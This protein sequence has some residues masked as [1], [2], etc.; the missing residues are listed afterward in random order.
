MRPW[1]ESF[2]NEGAYAQVTFHVFTETN[3]GPDAAVPLLTYSQPQGIYGA[4]PILLDFYLT[5]APLRFLAQADPEDEIVDWRVRATINGEQFLIDRWEPIYLTGFREGQNWIKLE[6]L[7]DNGEPLANR[8]N[9]TAQLLEYYPGG[10]DSLSRLVRGELSPDEQ[11]ALLVPRLAI[12][13]DESPESD[14]T[15]GDR[16]EG[17]E[18]PAVTGDMSN[19]SLA[20]EEPAMEPDSPGDMSDEASGEPLETIAPQDTSETTRSDAED[21]QPQSLEPNQPA[22]ETPGEQAP[23]PSDTTPEPVDSERLDLS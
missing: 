20:I 8:F 15:L 11:Q 6:F 16:S 4:E 14:E 21:P 17:R 9:T 10:T 23:Q 19:Q 18:N 12:V 1:Q 3:P 22:E 7:G 5:Q 2:K 13:E